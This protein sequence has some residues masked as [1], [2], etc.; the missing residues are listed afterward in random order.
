MSCRPLL[1]QDHVHFYSNILC[2]TVPSLGK[3]HETNN[4]TTAA[5]RQHTARNNG[6]IDGNDIFYVVPWL[7][8]TTDKVQFS[9]LV[10]ARAGKWR[11]GWWVNELVRKLQFG[12]RE[13]LLLEASSWGMGTVQEPR[14]SGMSATGSCYQAI[15]IEDKA[16]WEESVHAVVNCR[17][18]KLAITSYLLVVTICKCSIN[19]IT[20]PYPIYSHTH[21]CDNTFL[22]L[23]KNTDF[24]PQTRE[25]QWMS[26]DNGVHKVSINPI[27][28]SRTYFISHAQTPTSVVFN[29]FTSMAPLAN[30]IP[31]ATPLWKTG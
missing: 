1:L 10:Q 14:E 17:V 5:A 9:Q 7:Y 24:S 6:S 26:N 4:K 23:Y 3:S 8:H 2:H 25:N 29:L 27:I 20:N 16:D 13:L 11:V 21:T 22:R 19:T 31:S 12:R 28:Q 30:H 15:T 18:C